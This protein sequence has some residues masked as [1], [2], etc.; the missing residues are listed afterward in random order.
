M[1]NFELN[2][3]DVPPGFVPHGAIEQPSIENTEQLAGELLEWIQETK[4]SEDQLTNEISPKEKL[5]MRVASVGADGI[6]ECI[7]RN[8]PDPMK[9][10]IKKLLSTTTLAGQELF[11]QRTTPKPMTGYHVAVKWC[12]SVLEDYALQLALEHGAATI[13]ELGPNASRFLSRARNTAVSH[14]CVPYME[15]NDTCRDRS[16]LSE[17]DNVTT[18]G[19]T[20]QECTQPAD[21]VFAFDVYDLTPADWEQI[22]TNAQ[23]TEGYWLVNYYSAEDGYLSYPVMEELGYR[24]LQTYT[25]PDGQKRVRHTMDIADKEYDNALPFCRGK[26][27]QHDTIR[28]KLVGQLGLLLLYKIDLLPAIPAPFHSMDNHHFVHALRAHTDMVPDA[29][30]TALRH[31]YRADMSVKQLEQRALISL[32]AELKMFDILPLACSMVVE[33]FERAQAQYRNKT[34]RASEVQMQNQGSEK[35]QD[36]IITPI[37]QWIGWMASLKTYLGEAQEWWPV[38]KQTLL[39][40]AKKARTWI[41]LYASRGWRL[42]MN[43]THS[44]HAWM[45]RQLNATQRFMR[46]HSLLRP[47]LTVVVRAKQACTALYHALCGLEG[48]PQVYPGYCIGDG[49]ASPLITPEASPHQIVSQPTEAG[50]HQ[51]AVQ[52]ILPT[53]EGQTT[54]V[55]HMCVANECAANNSRLLNIVSSPDPAALP[56]LTLEA[57]RL[58]EDHPVLRESVDAETTEQDFPIGLPVSLLARATCSETPGTNSPS[59]EPSISMISTSPEWINSSKMNMSPTPPSPHISSP[60]E[61]STQRPCGDQSC[62]NSRKSSLDCPTAPRNTAVMKKVSTWKN[63]SPMVML[64]SAST[65]PDLMHMSPSLYSE[66]PKSLC[67]PQCCGEEMI[68]STPSSLSTPQWCTPNSEQSYAL[69]ELE[70]QEMSTPLL[71]TPPSNSFAPAWSCVSSALLGEARFIWMAM[72]LFCSFL[73][74][75]CHALLTSPQPY[76]P[77]SDS[78]PRSRVMRAATVSCNFVADGLSTLQQACDTYVPPV[79]SWLQHRIAPSLSPLTSQLNALARLP[80][81]PLYSTAMCRFLEHYASCGPEQRG[82][83]LSTCRAGIPLLRENLTTWTSMSTT[84]LPLRVGGR[85]L[86]SLLECLLWN[87]SIANAILE[88]AVLH[89]SISALNTLSLRG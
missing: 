76:T 10:L 30:L 42:F 8:P 55:P 77:R 40:L 29:L 19:M 62:T 27:G 87:N 73:K 80:A 88:N 68:T 41:Q 70:T 66:R 81:V 38:I 18:C 13:K 44:L 53:V 74:Q 69:P 5:P 11:W 59:T 82:T 60:L 57:E 24:T 47:V 23:T 20:G 51:A 25:T 63:C 61:T 65:T 32:P 58:L 83:L 4:I 50:T 34:R 33:R 9:P 28:W 75:I 22:L 17:V 52:Q 84:P 86:P 46:R 1:S 36:K 48:S 56:E 15:A 16:R 7:F 71:E 85:I 49:A 31:L 12:R 54:S 78:R 14:A 64:P 37:Q 45:M 35:L 39:L 79:S 43:A 3:S 2:A 89:D 6:F 72:M 67:T 21:V 26:D